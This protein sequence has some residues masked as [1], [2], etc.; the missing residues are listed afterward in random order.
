M[1]E[2]SARRT[3]VAQLLH[4][5]CQ[6]ADSLFSQAVG[7]PALT[8]SQFAVL[9]AAKQSGGGSQSTLVEV[10]G[11][12]RSSMAD[13]VARLVKH[14]WLQRT[15]AE[16]DRRAYQV[17]LTAK[18]AAVLATVEPA[19]RKTNNALL[20]PLSKAERTQFLAALERIVGE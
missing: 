2:R 4:R 8:R 20:A 15:R 16:H 1:V 5:A 10:T 13:L 11:I 19:A 12:D 7:K 17:R 9:N 18:G 3:P 6:R 14:G